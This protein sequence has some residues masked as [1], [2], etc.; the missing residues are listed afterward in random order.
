MNNFTIFNAIVKTI[1]PKDMNG[2]SCWD[3]AIEEQRQYPTLHFG[4]VW[5]ETLSTR[6]YEVMNNGHLLHISGEMTKYKNKT[7]NVYTYNWKIT[8]FIVINSVNQHSNEKQEQDVS[9]MEYFGKE[10]ELENNSQKSLQSEYNKTQIEMMQE[11]G[12]IRTDDVVADDDNED[13][14]L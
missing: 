5:S 6:L 14:Q 2:H 7:T 8:D 12:V 4:K 13:F 3:V 9:D 1:T 10:Q 11:L